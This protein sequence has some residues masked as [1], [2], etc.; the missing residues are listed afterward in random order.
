MKYNFRQR[1]LIKEN[2]TAARK[3]KYC[4]GQQKIT[5]THCVHSH[6]VSATALSPL[7]HSDNMLQ[8]LCSNAKLSGMFDVEIPQLKQIYVT[9]SR[10]NYVCQPFLGPDSLPLCL[11]SLASLYLSLFLSLCLSV[12]CG[13]LFANIFQHQKYVCPTCPVPP[14][15]AFACRCNCAAVVSFYSS[16]SSFF[17]LP[18]PFVRFLTISIFA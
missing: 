4:Y 10:A 12:G 18:L 13:N 9:R 14:L 1:F 15:C 6:T 3:A 2:K 16:S 7:Q 11:Y 17:T 8:Q 5:H